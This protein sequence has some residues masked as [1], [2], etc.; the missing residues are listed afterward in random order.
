MRILPAPI[1]LLIATFVLITASEA[2]AQTE[3][4][5]AWKIE[6]QSAQAPKFQNR[7]NKTMLLLE[8]LFR[9][10]SSSQQSFII[11]KDFVHATI[12][13]E[14][15]V[16]V[17]GL[18]WQMADPAGSLGMR[19]I[20]VYKMEIWNVADEK[21]PTLIMAPGPVEVLVEPGKAYMQRV[22]VS[23]PEADSFQLKVGS[24]APIQVAVPSSR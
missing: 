23:R 10:Q 16:Q 9:N 4:T 18:L 2:L 24:M 15:P 11:S 8:V 14:K 3:S 12:A 5:S 6:L 22:L 13:G 20:G 19:Y 1:Q 17:L 21:T 7:D